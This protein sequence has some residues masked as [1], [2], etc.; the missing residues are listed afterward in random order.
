MTHQHCARSPLRGASSPHDAQFPVY[1]RAIVRF[2][3][4]ISCKTATGPQV[5]AVTVGMNTQPHQQLG[6]SRDIIESARSPFMH[7]IFIPSHRRVVTL[8]RYICDHFCF[9]SPSCIA[10]GGNTQDTPGTVTVLSGSDTYTYA[11]PS[12][13]WTVGRARTRLQLHTFHSTSSLSTQ[14]AEGQKKAP[15]MSRRKA[16]D[17]PI[18]TSTPRRYLRCTFPNPAEGVSCHQSL[19]FASLHPAATS[20]AEPHAGRT[21][22]QYPDPG[23]CLPHPI[24]LDNVDSCVCD[25]YY[26]LPEASCTNNHAGIRRPGEHPAGCKDMIFKLVCDRFDARAVGGVA[27]STAGACRRNC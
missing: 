20:H 2:C 16:L 9:S 5:I 1:A 27:E 4:V 7:M 15:A 8:E 12:L 3:V 10:N 24:D 11:W 22:L 26:P 13:C 23:L 25:P 18:T 19:F 21:T 6:T 17:N 14:K